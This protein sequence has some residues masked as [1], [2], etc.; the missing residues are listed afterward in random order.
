MVPRV[1][2]LV[3]A[4]GSVLLLAERVSAQ[5]D[6]T[7]PFPLRDPIIREIMV[8]PPDQSPDLMKPPLEA[9][10]EKEA[11][12]S[13]STPGFIAPLTATTPTSR[14][15]AAG[16]SVG[17]AAVGGSRATTDQTGAVGLGFAVEWGTPRPESP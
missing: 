6:G 10:R 2:L 16:W 3:V 17:G 7:P 5:G 1:V 12:R 9:E 8:K 15:G 4:L 11:A 14:Y 13:G